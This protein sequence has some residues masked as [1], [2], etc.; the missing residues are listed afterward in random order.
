[1]GYPVVDMDATTKSCMNKG[2]VMKQDLQEAAIA[3]DCMFKKEFCR[4]VLKRH[5]KWPMLSFDPQLNPHIVSCI[6]ENEWGE[7]TSLKWDPMDFQHV[8]LKKNFD[9]KK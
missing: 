8:H 1:M 7:T 5:N 4:Q 2:T 3:I 6:L 9:F